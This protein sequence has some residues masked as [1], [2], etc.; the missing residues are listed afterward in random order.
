[1]IVLPLDTQCNK[2]DCKKYGWYS[3]ANDNSTFNISCRE[4][5]CFKGGW[6]STQEVSGIEYNDIVT[7]IKGDC[8]ANGWNVMTGYDMMGGN[9]R[10]F[11][12][13]CSK[14]GGTSYW[15]GRPSY[16]VCYETDCY[17]KG[18]DWCVY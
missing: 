11:G 2:N 12:S 14:Y 17:H 16:T 13:D 15:R 6:Y 9:V 18:W 8:L 7:C 1:M 10:C 5:G 4:S 3:V